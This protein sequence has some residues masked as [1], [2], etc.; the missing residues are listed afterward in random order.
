[1]AVCFNYWLLRPELLSVAY[2]NDSSV[3]EQMVRF[4][5]AR[6]S[7]GHLPQTS[8]FPYLGLGSPQFLHYQSLPAT[9]TGLVGTVVGPNRAFVWSIYLLV[10]LWPV[11]VY[12]GAR[13]FRLNRCSAAAAAVLAPLVVSAVGVGYETRAYIWIGFGVWTQLWAMWT[14]PLAWGWSWRAVRGDGPFLPAVLWISLTVMFHYETGYLALLPLAILPW[15]TPSAWRPRLARAA[16]VAAGSLL[17][18]AWVTV[19]LLATGRWA[20]INEVLRGTPLENGYGAR[21]VLTWLAGG[22]LLDHGRLPVV[23]VLAGVGLVAAIV[24]FRTDERG[25]ALIALLVMSLVLSFGRTTFGPLVA[26][27]PASSDLFM[28]RFMM[29]VQLAALLL[30]GLGAGALAGGVRTVLVR[31]GI[32]RSEDHPEGPPEWWRRSVLVLVGFA[33]VVVALGAGMDPGGRPGQPER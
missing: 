8:W 25:R 6:L 31:R 11:S 17:A 12:L 10:S 4:A 26:V 28:R 9:L 2:L 5:A 29:G 32:W 27:L 23:T 16:V 18:T 3:H 21:Q 20:S 1:M 19:P 13:A 30:A 14:L 7:S 22:G 15:L 24:R 33:V